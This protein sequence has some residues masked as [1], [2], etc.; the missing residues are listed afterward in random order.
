MGMTT[1]DYV[2]YGIDDV[3]FL[4]PK[5]EAPRN[6]GRLLL[7][8]TV[9]PTN[10]C[11]VAGTHV[12]QGTSKV[13]IYKSQLKNVQ[14][15]VA[16]EAA[17]TAWKSAEE[18][19]ARALEIFIDD[20]VGYKLTDSVK[21][22]P[23]KMKERESQA[24]KFDG[25]PSFHLASMGF[26]KGIAPIRKLEILKELEVIKTERAES[27]NKFDKLIG[28]LEGKR[29]DDRVSKLEAQIARLEALL[30]EKKK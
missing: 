11:Y 23:E 26:P 22:S 5:N 13:I 8:V 10:G 28:A 19:H 9:A 2:D 20:A 3:Q 6:E 4:I 17:L 24:L 12:P 16:T 30:T 14:K 29:D 18:M 15:M 7:E 21:A 1:Q 27:D 25:S